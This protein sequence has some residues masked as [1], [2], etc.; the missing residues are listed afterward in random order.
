MQERLV[1]SR[2]Q[3]EQ[4]AL[5]EKIQRIKRNVAKEEEAAYGQLKKSHQRIVFSLENQQSSEIKELH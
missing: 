3:K 1:L 4:M 2:Q 5:L